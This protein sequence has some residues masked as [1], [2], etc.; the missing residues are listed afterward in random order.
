LKRIVEKKEPTSRFNDIYPILVKS[1]PTDLEK[2]LMGSLLAK[3]Y[4][5]E[6]EERALTLLLDK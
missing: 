1:T 2:E 4:P 6:F 5:M 3:F